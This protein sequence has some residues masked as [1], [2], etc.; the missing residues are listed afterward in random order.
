MMEQIKGIELTLKW[1]KYGIPDTERTKGE[2]VTCTKRAVKK[3]E[4]KF[5]M[6][7]HVQSLYFFFKFSMIV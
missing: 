6:N 1:E 2:E 5:S 4:L 7:F 3:M